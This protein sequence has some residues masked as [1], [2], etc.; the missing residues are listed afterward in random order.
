MDMKIFH[1]M[2]PAMQMNSVKNERASLAEY[3][4]ASPGEDDTQ[5]L[6]LMTHHGRLG[7]ILQDL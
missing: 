6:Q 5:L 7:F 3:A 1:K 2:L 4:K